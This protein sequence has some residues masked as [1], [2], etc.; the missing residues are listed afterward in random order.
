MAG[1]FEDKAWSLYIGNRNCG[2]GVVDTLCKSSLGQYHSNVDA[3]NLL[4]NSSRTLKLKQPEKQMAF[5]MDF[6][7]ARLTFSQEL[8]P[9]PNYKSIKLNADIIKK[10]CSGGDA[11]K[12]KRN[13]DVFITEFINQSRLIIMANDCPTLTNDDALQTCCE[14][15][16]T[17]S[18]KTK[19]K[20][21]ILVARGEHQLVLQKFQ[22][23]YP[24]IKDNCKTEAW[25]N[26]FIMLMVEAY[27]SNAVPRERLTLGA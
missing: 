12:W 22:V 14:F 17:I 10:L 1:H 27:Q 25:A 15:N 3:Q 26:A 21:D 18:F 20:I 6:Q 11:L 7:F 16:S 19:E 24:F 4:C 8:P 2:K 13:Y 23:G 5:A 9:P